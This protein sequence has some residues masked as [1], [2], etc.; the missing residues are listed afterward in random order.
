[1]TDEEYAEARAEFGDAFGSCV[2]R[3]TPQALADELGWSRSDVISFVD[4]SVDYVFAGD[5]IHAARLR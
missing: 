3:P 1:M 2:A 5:V 4:A